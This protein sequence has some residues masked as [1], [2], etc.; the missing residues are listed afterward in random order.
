M[1][2]HLV[3]VPLAAL[4]A[5]TPTATAAVAG[6]HYAGRTDQNRVVDFKVKGGAVRGFVAG[7]LTFCNTMGD[8]RFETDAIAH[9]PAMKVKAGGRFAW[10]GDIERDGTITMSVK[11]RITGSK[12]KGKVTLSRPDSYYDASQ[13]M[14][15]FGA[16]AAYDRAFTAKRR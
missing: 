12:V 3:L 9:V 4:L 1:R 15:M 11:G 5:A 16:C 10:S 7:V 8:N 13:G 6:G 2:R 14:T